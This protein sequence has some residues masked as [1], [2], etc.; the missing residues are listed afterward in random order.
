[1]FEFFA[2]RMFTL[3]KIWVGV[4]R[5]QKTSLP[6]IEN[7]YNNQNLEKIEKPDYNDKKNVW[8]ILKV[9]NFDYYHVLNLLNYHT[10][11]SGYY[12]CTT[13][14]KKAWTQALRR[15][16]SCSRRVGYSRWWE[17]PTMVPAENKAKF[18]SLVNHNAKR[19][20]HYHVQSDTSLL[21]DASENF[22]KM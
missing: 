9:K 10:L 14:F 15:F 22:R 19:I 8:N 18:L 6:V 7:F 21:S 13:S 11:S 4:I 12:D 20:H 16:Q 17:H 3:K 5:C 1:M 2:L